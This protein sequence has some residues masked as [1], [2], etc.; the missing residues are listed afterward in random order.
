MSVDI[1]PAVRISKVVD[2]GQD[3]ICIEVVYSDSR[4]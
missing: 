1:I 3:I 2:E 4:I